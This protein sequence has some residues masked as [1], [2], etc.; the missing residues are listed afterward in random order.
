MTKNKIVLFTAIMLVI[1][2]VCRLSDPSVK[3]FN[4]QNLGMFYG[5]HLHL[6]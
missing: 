1:G 3:D 6:F 2:L 4:D 5:L